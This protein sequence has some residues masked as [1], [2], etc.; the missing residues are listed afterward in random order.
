MTLSVLHEIKHYTLIEA[1]K[2]NADA[3]ISPDDELYR[4]EM[5]SSV[6]DEDG[7]EMI[8][9]SPDGDGDNLCVPVDKVDDEW[10]PVVNT[11]YKLYT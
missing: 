9:L 7:T 6:R 8:V 11:Y 10:I 3:L 5:D 2:E 4:R 1:S